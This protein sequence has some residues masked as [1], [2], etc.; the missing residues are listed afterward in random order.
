MLFITNLKRAEG[1]TEVFRK[2]PGEMQIH[3]DF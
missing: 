1:D 3:K 2:N